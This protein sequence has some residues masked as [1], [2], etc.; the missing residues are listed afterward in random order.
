MRKTLGTV[1]GA[2]VDRTIYNVDD[3]RGRE[4]VRKGLAAE[5]AD[6]PAYV[7]DLFDRLKAGADRPCLFLPFVGEFG[8]EVMSH[9]RIVHFHESPVKVVCCRP[10]NQV[11]YPS[12]S[13][14]VTDWQDPI[15]D[16]ARVA[17]M[18]S[19]RIDWSHILQRFP[20]HH[21]HAGANGLTSEQ[22]I[23][24]IKP[25]R[26]IEF[27]PKR[28]GLHADLVFGVRRRAFAP[29]RN[30]SHWQ[31][32]ADAASAAG[33]TFAVIGDKCTS[34]DLSG[35]VAHSGDFDTDAAVELLQNCR[36]YVGTDSGS[37]HLASTV[38]SRMLIFREQM[39]GSRD[40]TPRMKL[41]NPGRV[42]V[43]PGGWFHPARVAAEMLNLA[44]MDVTRG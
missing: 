41:V 5:T 11:L 3:A 37:S 35:Q 31:Q 13:A 9:L 22:E 6:P 36:L 34:F 1:D 16:A 8:H 39:H 7:A 2:F 21:A 27:H 23:F 14:F 30:W 29:E 10:G 33:L 43:L 28:R 26:R 4:W 38:G 32:L 42:S 15:P 40:L 18:R 24:A 44:R 19:S 17:T 12:A 25:D 20:G